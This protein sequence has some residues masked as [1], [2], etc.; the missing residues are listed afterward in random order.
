MTR[1]QRRTRRAR[2]LG[3]IPDHTVVGMTPRRSWFALLFGF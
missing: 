1:L 2:R 3:L